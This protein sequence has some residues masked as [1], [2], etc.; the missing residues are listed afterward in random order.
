MSKYES[1]KLLEKLYF[2]RTSGSKE[3]LKAANIL[4]DEVKSLGVKDVKLEG[5]EVD[6]YTINHASVS[7][8]NPEMKLECCGVGMSGS[9]SEDGF[10][11]D[12]TYVTSL[13]DAN[14]QDVKDKAVLVCGKLVNYKIYKKLCEK[15]A[16]ALI[17]T[18]GSVYDEAD[19]VDLDPYMYRIRHY[20]NGKI[21]AV[22][23]RN[24]DAEELIRIMP[25]KAT[26]KN[27]EDE[28]KNTSNNVV[29]TI[30]GSKYPD[31]VIC[32]TAHYDS[33]SYSKGAYDNATG[34][35]CIMQL[36]DY[37][38]HN[39]PLRTVKFIWCGSEECGLLGSKAYCERHKKELDKYV[40]N[41]NLDMIGV[42]LG[43]DIACAT[44]DMALVNFINYEGLI[45]GFA[46]EARQ[47]VYSS[48]STPFADHG[49]PAVSFARLSDSI[50]AQIHSRKDVLDFLSEANY[51]RTIDFITSFAEK[52]V[53][54]VA[55][56]I[57]RKIPDKIKEEIDY[58]YGRK[59]RE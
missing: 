54:A 5:F 9:T 12:F 37:F 11:G 44:A 15:K 7:F 8:S 43:K 23:I 1:F 13:A 42:T 41:I 33:V 22:C 46:I 20:E 25:K 4:K 57:E 29:A 49:V 34:S 32:F 48:D 50:G 30:K 6:G 51:Y 47:G 18:T 53:N 52:M 16:G 26:V 36:L 28:Y 10:T 40:L 39:K 35:T 21:P 27:L 59:E 58:Y 56:P 3:E 14:V 38:V 45:K 55:F 24:K 19:K 2:V 31:E 17:L